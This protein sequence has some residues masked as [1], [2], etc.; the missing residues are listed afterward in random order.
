M[1]DD[2]EIPEGN[3]E[4]YHIIQQLYPWGYT[5]KIKAGTRTVECTIIHIIQQVEAIQA[6]MECKGINTMWFMQT[7]MVCFLLL[8]TQSHRQASHKEVDFGS[9]FQPRG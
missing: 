8:L 1:D 5:Q 2:M 6:S 4:N 7:L 9:Q 3:K